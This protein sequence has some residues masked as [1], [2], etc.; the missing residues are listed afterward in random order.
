MSAPRA[1]RNVTP[2][3]A[4]LRRSWRIFLRFSW[5]R[6]ARNSSKLP[7]RLA[8]TPSPPG[9]PKAKGAPSGG[10]EA[11]AVASVGAPGTAAGPPQ[12]EGR[13]LGGQRGHVSAERGGRSCRRAAPRR[14]EPP[15][16]AAKHTQWR[17]WGPGSSNETAPCGAQESGASQAA[18]SSSAA[19]RRCSEDSCP[20]SSHHWTQRLH[21][22]LAGCGVTRQQPGAGHGCEGHRHQRFRVVGQAMLGVG[23]CPGPVEHVFAV[24]MALRYSGQA[25]AR[26]APPRASESRAPSRWLGWRCRCRAATRGFPG[27]SASGL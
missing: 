10:S 9:R 19:N 21:Q 13:P 6:L 27:Y 16:G 5:V 11:H 17:A 2:A 26:V 1:Q 24:G 4:T 25:A 3:S 8:G 12:G 15:R 18:R 20:R 22:R 14:R 7:K 23:V